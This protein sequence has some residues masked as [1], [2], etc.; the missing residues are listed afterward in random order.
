MH[1]ITT[2]TMLTHHD[3]R[4]L[5][6]FLQRLQALIPLEGLQITS[7]SLDSRIK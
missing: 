3:Y 4:R 1:F 5:K 6:I 2:F 7:D